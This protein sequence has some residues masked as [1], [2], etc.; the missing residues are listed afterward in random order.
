MVLYPVF[1]KQQSNTFA[2]PEMR[3]N[4]VLIAFC[5]ARG[6]LEWVTPDSLV[7][8]PPRPE[9]TVAPDCKTLAVTRCYWGC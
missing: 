5:T 1:G 7:H 6:R 8:L 2:Q 9:L 4:N 3:I